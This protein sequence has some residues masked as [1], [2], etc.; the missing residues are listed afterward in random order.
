[1]MRGMAKRWGGAFGGALLVV[2]SANLQ[3]G[4][5]SAS[6]SPGA[7]VSLSINGSEPAASFRVTVTNTSSSNTINS[8]RFVATSAVVN[9]SVNAKAAFRSATVYPCAPSPD[10]T[11][12]D[13]AL[14]PLAPGQSSP[15]FIVTFNAPTS[16]ESIA[17]AWQ[18][19]FNQGLPPGNSNGETGTATLE[20]A[21]IDPNAV[22]SD[23]PVDVAL[24]FFTG[25]GIATKDDP[26]VTRV[27]VPGS[28]IATRATILE[29]V[30]S[31]SIGGTCA[32]ASNLLNCS[33]TTLT[34]PGATFAGPFLEITLLRDEST[35]AKGAKIASA[36]VIYRKEQDASGSCGALACSSYPMELLSCSNTSTYGA[37]PQ[38]GIPCI[39]ERQEFAKK[40]TG[41]VFVPPGYEGDW[42]FLIWA[43]D[44][45]R[46]EN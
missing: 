13:C 3:A 11:S 46:F 10:L 1:M 7:P 38:P 21:P 6:V 24:F 34:I 37:L 8:P 12:I 15:E 17:L 41:K 30:E 14:S 39:K 32:Q 23:V 28:A 18:A 27:D 2:L 20:L 4:E 5:I 16:G 42:R 29:L 25:S 33:T 45:G 9:G 44:N 26:W 36:R 35:L 22:Q 43:V 31:G 40:S 19:V